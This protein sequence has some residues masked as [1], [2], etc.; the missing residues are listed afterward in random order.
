MSDAT[1]TIRLGIIGCGRATVVHHLPAIMAIPDFSVSAIADIDSALCNR[2]A[3][4]HSIPGRF[5]S[6]RDLLAGADVDAVVVAT[7]TS[8]HA[9]IGLDIIEAGK[10]M[11][12]EKPL[13]LNL[14]ECDG[15]IEAADRAGTTV[16]VAHNSRWHR[17]ALRAREMV[18]SGMLG[19]LKAIRSVYTHAHQ[20][21]SP[22][23]W[24][25]IRAEG[26]GVIH[27]D[28]VHHFDLWRFLLGTEV[29]EVRAHATDSEHFEDDTCTVTA[30]LD[31]GALGS[32]VFS[33][34]TSQNSEIEIFGESGCLLLSLYRFEGLD[35]TPNTSLPG[36][37]PTRIRQAGNF[38]RSL[39]AGL[40]A[41]R[42]GG[43]FDATYAAMW[44]HFADCLLRGATPLCGLADGRASLSVALA[45]IESASAARAV[46]LSPRQRR[47]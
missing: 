21:P 6:H 10:N 2:I 3:D 12:M 44:R 7:P 20:R 27:N 5:Q 15:L 25:R 41:M 9:E 29:T 8:T 23:P 18:A 45:C 24:H 14:A 47:L 1:S 40:A 39:P 30:R 31:N 35:F 19:E 34:S 17:L 42:A 36:S 46:S 38:L 4:S 16:L 43:D 28:S 33:F 11:F 26:G 37:I 22:Q 13:A 32:A